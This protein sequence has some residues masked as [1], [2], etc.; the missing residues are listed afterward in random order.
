MG[1][2]VGSHFFDMVE[3][4]YYAGSKYKMIV[5]VTNTADIPTTLG[6]TDPIT[7]SLVSTDKQDYITLGYNNHLGYIRITDPAPGNFEFE[8]TP[9]YSDPRIGEFTRDFVARADVRIA[10]I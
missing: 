8:L 3:A 7:F 5:R 6:N 1:D 2:V 10:D 4:N 9:S